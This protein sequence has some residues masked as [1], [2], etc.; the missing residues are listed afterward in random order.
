MNVLST[1]CMQIIGFHP[2]DQVAMLVGNTIQFLQNLHNKYRQSHDFECNL[3][4]ISTIELIIFKEEEISTR[5]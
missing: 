2:H 3:E 4:L 5:P 1:C